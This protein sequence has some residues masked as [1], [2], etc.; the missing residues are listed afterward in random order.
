MLDLD[1]SNVAGNFKECKDFLD[2]YM[3]ASGSNDKDKKVQ[4]VIILNCAGPQL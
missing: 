1:G 3:L 2:I 4:R